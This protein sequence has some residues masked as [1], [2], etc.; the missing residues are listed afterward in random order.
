MALDLNNDDYPG[1]YG[2][3]DRA[4]QSAQRSFL[5]V[6]KARLI[7]L[8][9]AGLAASYSWTTKGTDW[10][11]IVA[12]AS[13]GLTLI[14]EVYLL[15]NKLEATWYEGRAAAESIKTLTWRYAV[16]GEP[17]G[18][19]EESQAGTD[20]LFLDRLRQ[21]LY[22]LRSLEVSPPGNLGGQISNGMRTLRSSA[23]PERIAA[24]QQGRVDDQ[25]S[26]Y[27]KNAQWN[28]AKGT[29]W[30]V[31]LLL[32]EV[33]GFMGALARAVG[34]VRLDLLGIAGTL[35]A[36]A[37]AWLQTKQHRTLARAYSVAAHELSTVKSLLN[38]S[39]MSESEWARFMNEAEEAISREHTLWRAS[40]GVHG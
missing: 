39:E 12:A 15:S 27:S 26:W 2:A 1:L 18:L 40:R 21:T 9:V 7:A 17:F 37:T 16:G 36:A 31:G 22:D 5:F 13:F 19:E 38:S 4:S 14:G 34:I 8:I 32:I 10:F 23:L 24:Y 35:A 30:S 3:T 28:K 25:Q 20:K 6:T 11:A 33:F 29:Q